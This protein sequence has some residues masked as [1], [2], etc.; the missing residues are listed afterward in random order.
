[1]EH[2]CTKRVLFLRHG[3]AVHNPRAEAAREAGCTHE[4]FLEITRQDDAFDSPLTTLGEEQAREVARRDCSGALLNVGLVVASSLSRALRTAD[5]TFPPPL[6]SFTDG[7]H[8]RRVCLDDFREINGWLLN[9][10][11]RD[12]TELNNVFG[13]NW[14]FSSLTDTDKTWTEAREA[15]EKAAQRGYEGLIWLACQEEERIL[16]VSHGGLLRFLMNGHP[17]V[18]LEDGRENHGTDQRDVG[19]RFGNCEL[20]EFEMRWSRDN[21]EKVSICHS[22]V[23]TLT[24][25]SMD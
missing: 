10:R 1:M 19:A 24:E 18:L 12:R 9:G 5:L 16:V 6:S 11:R 2:T 20:R 14:D 3:Q 15:E 7:C 23:F 13:S 25:L 4:H 22:P 17:N 21:S 8:P